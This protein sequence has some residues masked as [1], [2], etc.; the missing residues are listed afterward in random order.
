M[1]ADRRTG[2]ALTGDERAVLVS[3]L[4][5]QRD[6]L[7]WTCSD[8]GPVQLAERAVPPSTL[9]PTGSVEHLAAVERSWSQR[10][11][12]G[13][14]APAFWEPDHRGEPPPDLA[15]IERWRRECDRSRAFVDGGASL[16]TEVEHGGARF[17]LRYVPIHPIEE[18]ARHNGHADPL[19]ERL[20]GSTG[21]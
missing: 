13:A 1:E 12:Q 4:D 10:V 6:T 7:A 15:P 8:L 3:V 18:Y 17:S 2:P 11:L 5:R 21:E 16:D 9:S 19:R 14:D 20:D